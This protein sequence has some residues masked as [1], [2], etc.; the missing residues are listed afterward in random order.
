MD[1]LIGREI[2]GYRIEA[3]IGRGGQAVVYRATQ[4]SLQRTVALKVVSS[5]LSS[6]ASFRERFAREGIA[7]ASLDHPH[8]VPVFEAGEADGLAFL[9]MKFVDGPSLDA[10]I[11]APEGAEVRRVLAI[12][13]QVAEALDY[14]S[15]RGMVHRDVKPANVLL[16]PGDHAYLTDFGLIKAMSASRLT[17]TGM[18]MGTLEYVAPEQLRGEVVT[19]AADRYALGALA[20][21]ALTGGAVFPRE[22]RAAALY[23][24]VNSDPPSAS[25][26]NPALGAPVDAVLARSLAKDPDARHPSALAFVGELESAVAAT[27]G[28]AA[29]RPPRAGAGPGGGPPVGPTIAGETP[30]SSSPPPPPPPPP[31]APAPPPAVIGRDGPAGGEP[32][33]WRIPAI[34]GGAI[35]ALVVVIAVVMLSSGG[36]GQR[37]VTT[38]V[39]NTGVTA[40]TAPGLE[41]TFPIGAVLPDTV[42]GWQIAPT[43]PGVVNLE[44]EDQGA[45][46]SAQATR[47]ADVGLLVGLRPSNEDGR[48]AVERLRDDLGGTAEGPVALGG[49]AGEGE[50]QR[51]GAT[52]AVSFATPDRAILAVANGRET[53]VALAMAASEA[54]G[55]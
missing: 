25:E 1:H 48:I 51:D 32:A 13:R 18:W 53:A 54:L 20:F 29:A 19:P 34:V 30:R 40:V 4:I 42:E 3:E 39:L 16:G 6:D 37:T 15:E 31:A 38:L 8:I 28:A 5:Q 9:A 17:S 43:D 46:E 55:P 11:H 47:G 45:V 50:V 14:V 44:L 33:R 21:E 36:G 24:H 23:A 41:T 10:V 27:P 49:V 52:V 7:A 22:D 12:L 2:E 26:R 35:A